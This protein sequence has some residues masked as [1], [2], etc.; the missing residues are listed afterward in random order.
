MVRVAQ[1]CGGAVCSLAEAAAGSRF[2]EPCSGHGLP[3]HVSGQIEISPL[4][5]LPALEPN[6]LRP[7]HLPLPHPLTPPPLPHIDTTN[8]RQYDSIC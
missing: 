1:D 8:R 6:A 5:A 3:G 7:P 4:P 2:S